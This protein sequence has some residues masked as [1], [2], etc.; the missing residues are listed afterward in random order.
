MFQYFTANNLISPNQ[1]GFRP[2]DSCINQLSS[3]RHEIYWSFD[4]GF[5]VRG[6]FPDISKAFY[7]VWRESLIF[8]VN[9]YGISGNLLQLAKS[10]L[11]NR[12]HRVFFLNGEA[13][14]WA[15]V[16]AGVPQGSILG[17][18]LFLIYVNDLS[19]NLLS[20]PKLFADDTFLFSVLHYKILT[21]EDLNDNFK[22]YV[23]G[24]NIHQWKMSFNPDEYIVSESQQETSI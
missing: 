4:N 3:I 10:F 20:D 21:A 8:K 1:S 18:L 5:E 16:M 12:K 13:L 23:S 7:K 9:Q 11:K 19:D 6:V 24:R 2:G 14:S 22:K 17:P 15:N